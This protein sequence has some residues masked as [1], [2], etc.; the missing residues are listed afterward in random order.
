MC[1]FLMTKNRKTPWNVQF[2][3]ITKINKVKEISAGF[4]ST[5]KIVLCRKFSPRYNFPD[6]N[7]LLHIFYL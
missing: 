1:F 5:S 2:S 3:K 6:I 7:K 4:L